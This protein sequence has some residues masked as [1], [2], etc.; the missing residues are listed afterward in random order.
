MTSAQRR[1]RPTT[2]FSERIAIDKRLMTVIGK[3]MDGQYDIEHL[4]KGV[5]RTI[6]PCFKNFVVRY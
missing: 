6:S 1:N 3:K 5:S 2:H 4:N